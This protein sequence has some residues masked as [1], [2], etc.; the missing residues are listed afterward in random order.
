MAPEQGDQK[1]EKKIAQSFEK[2][3]QNSFQT[4]NAKTSSSNLNLKVQNINS[5]PFINSQNAFNKP[6]FAQKIHPGL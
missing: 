3:A 5:K 4:K 2:V 6:Y 1:I